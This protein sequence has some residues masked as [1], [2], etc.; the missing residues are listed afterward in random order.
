MSEIH[1]VICDV[2]GTLTDGNYTVDQAGKI[3]K[4]FNTRDFYILERLLRNR[5]AVLIA[6]N[7][8]DSIIYRKVEQFNKRNGYY[9]QL[10]VVSGYQSNDNHVAGRKD[11]MIE[12]YM[13]SSLYHPGKQ[14][15]WDHAAFIGDADND[16]Q[17]MAKAK[18]SG[19]PSDAVDAV[20][21]KADYLC[22]KEGGRGAVYEFGS[23]LM[24]KGFATKKENPVDI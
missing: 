23:W 20:K 13:K 1:L 2:D 7:A 17:C 15:D 4:S 14:F 8:T 3:S 24:E 19:C 12:N 5:V 10:H 18:I 9:G 11:S 6:T 22:S 16:I 21:A